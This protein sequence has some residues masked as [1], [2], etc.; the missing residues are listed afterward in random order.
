[1]AVA[2][3][4]HDLGV[5]ASLC[6][7]MVVMYGGLIMETDPVEDIFYRPLHPYTQALLRSVPMIRQ[8]QQPG[9]RQERLTTI[10]GQPPSALWMPPGCP[11]APR[12]TQAGTGCEESLPPMTD[13]GPG[14]STR[15]FRIH[16][17]ASEP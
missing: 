2:L 6:H 12:Y 16:E 4:T 14:R 3:I 17:D 1:M 8:S 11:F 10:E 15:C 7:R 13:H 9:S 5:V